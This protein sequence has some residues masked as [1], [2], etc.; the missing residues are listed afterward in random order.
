MS[1][2][3]SENM[4]KALAAATHPDPAKRLPGLQAANKFDVNVNGLYRKKEWRE[5]QEAQK[6][7]E[8]P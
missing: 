4:K 3:R 8:Q 6:A 1:R 5:F 2:P 7:R